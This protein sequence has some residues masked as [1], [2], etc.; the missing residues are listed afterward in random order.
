MRHFV[1]YVLKQP[2]I[3]AAKLTSEAVDDDCIVLFSRLKN[4]LILNEAQ[5][6]TALQSEF[7]LP[8]VVLRMEEHSFAHQVTV[9]RRARIAV[10]L[11]GWQLLI[12]IMVVH[13][14]ACMHAWHCSYNYSHSFIDCHLS[15]DGDDETILNIR[16]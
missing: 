13:I 7:K 4:R 3:I 9:L 16:I 2:R 5:V 12:F 10:G 1:S 6:I 14:R 15:C 8:V 11:H